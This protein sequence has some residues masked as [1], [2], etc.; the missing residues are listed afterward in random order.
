M[1]NFVLE[2]RLK[3]PQKDIYYISW[4]LD[5]CEGL[6]LLKTDDAAAG[7]ITLFTPACQL[8]TILGFIQG[9]RAE[10]IEIDIENLD[11]M[12]EIIHEQR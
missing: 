8:E 11:E 10:G 12:R 3:V 1:K 7:R 9:H 4:N 2:L 5:A 6:G